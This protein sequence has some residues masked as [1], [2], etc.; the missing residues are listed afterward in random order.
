MKTQ[1]SDHAEYLRNS[2]H[3][4]LKNQLVIHK[5]NMIDAIE[6]KCFDLDADLDLVK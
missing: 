2:S 1:V 6:T 3:Q 5:K 4:D